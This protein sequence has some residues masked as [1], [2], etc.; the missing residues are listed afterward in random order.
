MRCNDVINV[1]VVTRRHTG[2]ILNMNKYR[3]KYRNMKIFMPKL[4]RPCISTMCTILYSDVS[5]WPWPRGLVLGL[6]FG[7]INGKDKMQNS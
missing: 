6:V 7:V 2:G 5:P 1:I 4:L 3:A